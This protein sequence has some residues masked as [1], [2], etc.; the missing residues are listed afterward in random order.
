MFVLFFLFG[1]LPVLA[2]VLV[3]VVRVGL[4]APAIAGTNCF[5]YT[6]GGLAAVLTMCNLLVF[7]CCV[8]IV[9]DDPSPALDDIERLMDHINTFHI[10]SGDQLVRHF[11]TSLSRVVQSLLKRR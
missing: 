4:S 2:A 8:F 7:K 1:Y 9:S 3:S 10:Q 6:A 11:V 5:A